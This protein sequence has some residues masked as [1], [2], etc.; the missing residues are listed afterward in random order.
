LPQTTSGNLPE[1]NIAVSSANVASSNSPAFGISE[2]NILYRVGELIIDLPL[3][4]FWVVLRHYKS[5]RQKKNTIIEKFIENSLSLQ[6][7]KNI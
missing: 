4:T 3:I 7:K 5:I 6:N 1:T 2:R